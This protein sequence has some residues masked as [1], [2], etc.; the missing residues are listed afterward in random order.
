MF[1][2]IFNGQKNKLKAEVEQFS[3]F[4]QQ[5]NVNPELVDYFISQLEQKNLDKQS[6]QLPFQFKQLEEFISNQKMAV[7]TEYAAQLASINKSHNNPLANIKHIIAVASGKG[8]VGKSTTSVNIARALIEQ[9]AA[10]GI[11][12][13][14]IYGPSIPIMLG[15]ENKTPTS[16]DG[17]I[18]QPLL[19]KEGIRTNS[20]GFL[21]E[22]E[23]AAIWRGP[24]ASKALT[25]LFNETE[26]G[27]LDYLIIDLPPGTGDIQLTITQNLPL[28]A[29]V[30][31]TTPQNVA[32]ADADKGIAMFNK[33][34]IP[35]LGVV[36]NMSSFICDNCGHVDHIFGCDGGRNLASKHKVELLGEIPLST[37]IRVLMDQGEITDFKSAPFYQYCETIALELAWKLFKLAQ[38][39]PVNRAIP[40]KTI[41]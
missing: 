39:S 36:E 29:A 37:K 25:Q 6:L 10:V 24:M 8:G 26:W 21:V 14:D 5:K 9:G 23:A 20:I 22:Q 30:V 11:L 17:R 15:L 40:I 3:T 16:E 31:V 33:L 41:S 13:A 12:D 18:M 32:L 7:N 38:H 4:L 34:D 28:S 2:T 35:V 1:K 27:C 19:S